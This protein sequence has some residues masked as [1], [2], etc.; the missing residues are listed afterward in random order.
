MPFCDEG[1]F[2]LNKKTAPFFKDFVPPYMEPEAISLL[3]S[4]A[5]L[6]P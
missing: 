5:I 6:L 1:G 4:A 3:I 2:R